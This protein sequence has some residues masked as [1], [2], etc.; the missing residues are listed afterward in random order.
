MKHKL[1]LLLAL[2][3]GVV[4]GAM[5]SANRTPDKERVREALYAACVNGP[6]YAPGKNEQV[7][8]NRQGIDLLLTAT[9][10]GSYIPSLDTKK[11]EA[12]LDKY[13]R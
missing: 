8:C 11:Y 5:L 7:F 4:I 10:G 3:A 9:Y 2:L 6:N 12:E 13:K 1:S